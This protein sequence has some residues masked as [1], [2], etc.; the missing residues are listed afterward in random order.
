MSEA[1]HP[2]RAEEHGPRNLVNEAQAGEQRVRLR[3]SSEIT[4]IWWSTARKTAVR[5]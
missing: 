3:R 2:H 1:G 5:R 4:S